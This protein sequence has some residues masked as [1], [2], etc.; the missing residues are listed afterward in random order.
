MDTP[1]KGSRFVGGA[2]TEAVGAG[3]DA[4]ADALRGAPAAA[5]EGSLPQGV[6]A[7]GGTGG[8]GA[9]GIAAERGPL[10]RNVSFAVEDTDLDALLFPQDAESQRARRM[11]SPQ[12]LVVVDYTARWC[13]ACAG[14][15]PK[16]LSAARALA[17]RRHAGEARFVV[18]EVD[19]LDRYA[20]HF[21]VAPTFVFYKNGIKVDELLGLGPVVAGSASAPADGE[22]MLMDRCWL[23]DDGAFGSEV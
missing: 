16:F 10:P 21:S 4:S 14:A 3:D 19:G 18:A 1:V 15:M 9:G 17:A 22:Q 11:G 6:A 5:T 23:H 8:L 20:S 12:R 13:R 7:A 2:A